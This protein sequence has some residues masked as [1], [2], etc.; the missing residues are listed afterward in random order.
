MLPRVL[1]TWKGAKKG[2]MVAQ[3]R[4]GEG[5]CGVVNTFLLEI[6]AFH[7]LAT[8]PGLHIGLCALTSVHGA[9]RLMSVPKGRHVVGWRRRH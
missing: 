1:N 9:G 7:Y 3:V 8:G 6:I 5:G 4:P 2:R